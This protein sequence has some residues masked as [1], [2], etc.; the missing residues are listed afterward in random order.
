ME[1][2]LLLAGGRAP[3]FAVETSCGCP[4]EDLSAVHSFVRSGR[5]DEC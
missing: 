1:A 4:L 2:R 5:A 3:D